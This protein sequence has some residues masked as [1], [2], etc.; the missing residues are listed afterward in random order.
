MSKLL[1]KSHNVT[2]LLY[3][4]VCVAKYRR[5]VLDTS[6][7][8]TL[9]D[10]CLEIGQRYDVV[11]L[12]IGTDGDHVHFLVQ[13]IPR[14]SPSRLVQMIKSL[15]AREMFQRMPHVK[16]AL[17]GGEFWSDGYFMSTVG[18]HSTEVVIAEYV[19]NQGTEK[20]YNRLHHQQ[21]VLF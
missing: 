10:I 8:K 18:Q 15:T 1:H 4:L 9:R 13:S 21:L 5:V 19:R 14:Y 20:S 3:H 2:V 11:F 16:K 17:W 6:V 7:D 12:E